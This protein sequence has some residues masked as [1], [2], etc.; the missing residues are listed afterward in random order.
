MSSTIL[1]QSA[2]GS[3][4]FLLELSADGSPATG[5]TYTDVSVDLRKEG[6]AFEAFALTALNFTEVGAGFYDIT[7]DEDDT[8][9]LG[10]LYLRLSGATIKTTLVS[11]YVAVAA[12]VTPSTAVSV[13][14]TVL[15][16][17]LNG[18]D[19][20]PLS[21]AAVSARILAIPSV[22]YPASEA[23]VLGTGLLTVKTDS[24][25]FFTLSLVTGSDVDIF[26]PAAGYR[27]TLR[28]P[29]TSQNLFSIV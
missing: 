10:N 20:Q 14:T 9:T 8:D 19:G 15:F 5:L 2:T 22:Q 1:L 17:Y 11:A 21:G 3:V 7:L 24:A 6:G 12:S 18:V 16:G 27:R 26:I 29:S 13:P 28:V 23:V 25:G 4:T